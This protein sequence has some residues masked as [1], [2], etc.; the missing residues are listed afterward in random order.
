[1]TLK[2]DHRPDDKTIVLLYFWV[3][4][5]QGTVLSVSLHLFYFL[6][7]PLSLCLSLLLSFPFPPSLPLPPHPGPGKSVPWVFLISN[8][9]VTLNH[10]QPSGPLVNILDGSR[11]LGALRFLLIRTDEKKLVQNDSKEK[12]ITLWGKKTSVIV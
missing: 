2:N 10:E 3:T 6:S 1:M 11:N 7:S 4:S 9:T 12:L 5:P 8:I